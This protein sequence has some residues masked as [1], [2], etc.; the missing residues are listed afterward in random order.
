M[1][2]VMTVMFLSHC[3]TAQNLSFIVMLKLAS[4]WFMASVE[5]KISTSLP[6][7]DQGLGHTLVPC[8]HVSSLVAMLSLLQ[9][10]M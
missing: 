6:V 10:V 2:I 5:H 9:G 7:R 8:L 1:F 3:C 4:C